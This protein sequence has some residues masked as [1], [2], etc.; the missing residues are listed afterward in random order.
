MAQTSR[1]IRRQIDDTRARIGTAIAELESKVNPRRVIDDHPLATLGAAFAAG[2]L[3]SST[4]ATSRA[5]HEVRD[6]VREGADR[7]NSTT[8]GVVQ[9][10]VD[11]VIGGVSATLAARMGDLLDRALGSGSAQASKPQKSIRA[12]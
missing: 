10:M 2:L 4:D 3:L 12:A 9:N 8:E 6:R 1:E 7:V 11:A 5:A